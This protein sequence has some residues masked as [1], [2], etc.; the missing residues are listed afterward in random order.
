MAGRDA[1]VRY[2]FLHAVY[3]QV[4]HEWVSPTPLPYYHPRIGERKEQAYEERS[5]EIAAEL[6]VHFEQGREYERAVQYLQQVS[7]NAVQRSAHQEAVALFTKRLALL[8]TLS[9]ISERA[10]QELTLQLAL[11]VEL[12]AA[13]GYG[14]PAVEHVYNRA[15]ELC[16][17]IGEPPQLFSTVQGLHIMC[18]TARAEFPKARSLAEQLLSLAQRQHD[19]VLLVGAHFVLG[20]T[21]FLLG[22]FILTL[23]HLEQELAWYD[24]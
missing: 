7:E 10:Q 20:Q 15:L 9:D 6:A 21:L 16:R 23:S 12:T 2:S 4:W 3:Q 5:R 22:E 24:P 18:D 14:A 19:P 8:R 11:G 1:G 17:Q 13:K